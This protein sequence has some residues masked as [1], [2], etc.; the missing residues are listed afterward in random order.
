MTKV[1]SLVVHHSHVS[2]KLMNGRM[3]SPASNLQRLLYFKGLTQFVI[4][5]QDPRLSQSQTKSPI[6][7]RHSAVT[8]R[9]CDATSMT[10]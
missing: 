4:M 3:E 7:T 1:S 8:E 10:T 6:L 9:C 2:S 5:M